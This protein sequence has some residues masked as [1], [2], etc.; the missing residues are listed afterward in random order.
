M[1]RNRQKSPEVSIFITLTPKNLVFAMNQR[2]MF[3]ID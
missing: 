1:V 2:K 3:L